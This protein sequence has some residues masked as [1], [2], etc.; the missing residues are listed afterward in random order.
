MIHKIPLGK[1]FLGDEEQEAVAEVIHTGLIAYGN[2]VKDFEREFARKIGKK[3]CLMVNSGTSALSLGI[4]TLGLKKSIII[5]TL[6]C[7][8]VLNA[9][10]SAGLNIIFADVDKETHN[11]DLSSIPDEQL[12]K[13]GGIIVTHA[14][15]HSVD[16]DIINHYIKEYD[17]TL[18][19]DFA[20]AT[21]GYFKNKRL[22]SFG[23]ISITSFYG[24]KNMTTGYGGAI[25]TDD[26]E[27]FE[28]CIYGRGD[29]LCEY[30]NDLIP[31][32]LR[33]TDIQAAIGIVQLKKLEKMI[34]MRRNA[35]RKMIEALGSVKID[36]PVEKIYAK[37]SYYKFQIILQDN[38]K[39]S[40]FI[41][42]MNKLGISVGT[43]YDPPLHQTRIAMNLLN[44]IPNLP[45]SEFLAP[46]TVSLPMYPELSD[47]DIMEISRAI[48]ASI[49]D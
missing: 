47:K 4:K 2:K 34:E 19:E 32:N 7:N 3:Y 40:H 16:F 43:L 12:R 25:L 1:P 18:I 30:Y 17:L 44:N 22:G 27:I 33:M 8:S 9:V 5:P 13:A 37:H 35:A 14:Y 38:I 42:N 26:E 45:M 10:L 11:I 28:K 20:Q 6:T 49:T 48:K 46:R 24:P 15:G 23:K 39:K 41:K 36:L 29:N 21:G 31:L